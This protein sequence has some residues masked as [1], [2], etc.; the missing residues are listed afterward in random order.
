MSFLTEENIGYIPIVI[1]AVILIIAGAVYLIAQ[2]FKDKLTKAE[3]FSKMKC[4]ALFY[5]SVIKS[6]AAYP[7]VSPYL[8]MYQFPDS[9]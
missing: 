7:V 3:H 8:T 5:V 6:F 2:H 9:P 1:C 4:S